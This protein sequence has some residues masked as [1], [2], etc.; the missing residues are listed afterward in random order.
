MLAA[1]RLLGG[2]VRARVVSVADRSTQLSERCVARAA[3][4]GACYQP[5]GEAGL[6]ARCCAS[7]RAAYRA[8]R[9]TSE[10]AS[11][12]LAKWF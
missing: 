7:D 11:D 8:F 12:S 5:A 1:A 6:G 4:R 9:C 3:G 2:G 10:T